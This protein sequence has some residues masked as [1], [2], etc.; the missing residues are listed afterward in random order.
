MFK[1]WCAAQG[2]STSVNLSHVLMDGG[3]LSV[4]YD[5]LKE[6]YEEYVHCVK[7]GEPIFVVEQKT[8]IYNFFLDIDYKD[9]EALSLERIEKIAKVICEKVHSLGGGDCLVS[10]SK[11]KVQ[12]GQV[13][14]G[15]HLNWPS[16]PV[17]QKNAVYL[18]G[19]IVHTLSKIYPDESWEKVIDNS[20]YGNPDKGTKGS[21]FR[22]P[23]SHKKG[24]HGDC[25]GS[26]CLVCDGTGKLTEVAYL[27]VF[28][29]RCGGPFKIMER[30]M[31][32]EPS[33]E[34]LMSATIRTQCTTSTQ[35]EPHEA[36]VTRKK[37]EGTFTRDQIKNQVADSELSALLETF[38]HNMKGHEKVR[39]NKLFKSD[40]GDAYFVGTDSSYCENAGKEHS[41]NHVWFLVQ[42]TDSKIAQKC[43]CRC[44]VLRK[45]GFCKDFTGRR[46]ELNPTLRDKLFPNKKSSKIKSAIAPNVSAHSN[47]H[48]MY[49]GVLVPKTR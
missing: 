19:H 46:Y 10:I 31:D 29:Y 9:S 32:S 1:E 16:F 17:D 42:E 41:S 12:N 36:V 15:V 40:K 43:F 4:P 11:P 48:S 49:S 45:G 30:I 22:M 37:R 23:W 18:R 38:I 3:V 33:V 26:G 25:G 13:K 5:K 24:K 44:D 28:T 14:S 47:I 34:V 20:V 7:S 2:F 39:I 6:F 21:G 35:I 27:P 8:D